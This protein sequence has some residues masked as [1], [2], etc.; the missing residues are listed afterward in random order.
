MSILGVYTPTGWETSGA[1]GEFSA[2]GSGTP[3]SPNSRSHKIVLCYQQSDGKIHCDRRWVGHN[4][5][6]GSVIN[7]IAA[8]EGRVKH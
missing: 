1:T 3:W 8:T 4:K 7:K 6:I 5:S 2:Q